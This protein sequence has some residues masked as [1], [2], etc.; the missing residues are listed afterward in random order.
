MAKSK[1]PDKIDTSIELPIVRDNIIQIGS[2]VMNSLR[3]AILQV[4]KTL[5]TNPNGIPSITVAERLNQSLDELGNIKKEAINAL[6]LISGPITNVEVSDNA[7]IAESKLDLDY[8]TS[9]LYAQSL[10]TK[11]QVDSF[12]DTINDLS[13]KISI[14]L[15]ENA[16]NAHMA[17]NIGVEDI[18]ISASDISEFNL[19]SQNVQ[20]VLEQFINNHVNFSGNNISETNNSHK[21]NQI[22]YDSLKS[23]ISASSVQEALDNLSGQDS[24]VGQTLRDLYFENGYQKSSIL[25]VQSNLGRVIYKNMPI[26]F[27]KYSEN[28]DD[29]FSEISYTEELIEAPEKYDFVLISDSLYQI[30]SIDT[31]NKSIV[32]FGNLIEASTSGQTANFLKNSHGV[33]SPAG[34]KLVPVFDTSLS[35][36][37]V[38]KV[39][40]PSTTYI[41]SDNLSIERIDGANQTFSIEVDNILI[42]TFSV[43]SATGNSIDS[44][45]GKINQECS[46]ENLPISAFRHETK[47]GTKIGLAIDY[48]NSDTK[49][50]YIKLTSSD[51]SLDF[52]GLS[53]YKDLKVYGNFGSKYQINGSEFLGFEDKILATD[54]EIISGGNTIDLSASTS[55]VLTSGVKENDLLQ[56]E[57]SSSNDGI[58]RI[59]SVSNTSLKVDIKTGSAFSNETSES[60][61][62]KIQKNSVGLEDIKYE[63]ISSGGFESSFVDLFIDQKQDVNFVQTFEMENSIVG[64]EPLYSIVEAPRVMSDKTYT[65]SLALINTSN[66]DEGFSITF[67]GNEKLVEL[68]KGNRVVEVISSDNEKFKFFIKIEGLLSRLDTAGAINTSMFSHQTL[69]YQNNLFLGRV[70]FDDF[71]GLLAG[72]DENFR[73]FLSSDLGFISENQITNYFLKEFIYNRFSETRSSGVVSGLNISN[74][75][76]STNTTYQFDVSSGTVYVSGERFEVPAQTIVTNINPASSD[77]IFISV[78]ES[79]NLVFEEPINVG[80]ACL[81][82]FDPENNA[83]IGTIEYNSSSSTF[84]LFDLKLRIND[85]DFK[86]FNDILVSPQEG[87]GHFKNLS[88]AIKIAKRFGEAFPSAGVPK[89]KLKAGTYK[90]TISIADVSTSPYGTASTLEMATNGIYID[91]PVI[92]EGEGEDTILDLSQ[93]FT[94]TT[95][96]SKSTNTSNRGVLRIMGNSATTSL[97][98][99][100]KA[101]ALSGNVVIKNLK[102]YNSKIVITDQLYKEGTNF[103]S[104]SVT[105]EGIYFKSDTMW[106]TSFVS[107]NNSNIAANDKSGNIRII[108]CKFEDCGI[109][110]DEVTDAERIQNYEIKG[111]TFSRPNVAAPTYDSAVFISDES[112]TAN[113][114]DL[115]TEK[116]FLSMQDNN[117]HDLTSMV[118]SPIS[119]LTKKGSFPKKGS[120]PGEYFFNKVV[121]STV[122]VD[123]LVLSGSPFTPMSSVDFASLSN[124]NNFNGINEFENTV[125]FNDT[126]TFTSNAIFEDIVAFQGDVTSANVEVENLTVT[127]E[128]DLGTNGASIG[129]AGQTFYVTGDVE[130]QGEVNIS[131]DVTGKRYES[132]RVEFAGLSTDTY[133]LGLMQ[134]SDVALSDPA[135]ATVITRVGSSSFKIAA[136]PLEIEKIILKNIT[137][138]TI[139]GDFSIYRAASGSDPKVSANYTIVRTIPIFSLGPY[140]QQDLANAATSGSGV[141]A[142]DGIIFVL[143]N[144]N[145]IATDLQITVEIIYSYEVT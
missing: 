99:F 119:S 100:P 47:T 115:L 2:E 83:I 118:Q 68:P 123:S 28:S 82:P 124:N 108:N 97:P 135:L 111:C 14:H 70:R 6:N 104:S 91:F 94:D 131:G 121:S 29:T 54:F 25:G 33:S 134:N 63:N 87:M 24:D 71:R 4:E 21:A 23:G 88:S 64:T 117:I 15:N 74:I 42:H 137:S 112:A 17:K 13:L 144:N 60:I 9:T 106:D 67:D 92:I 98:S 140:E 22:Y 102:L 51:N 89:I 81:S 7:S 65:L 61:I 84:A 128:L 78:D 37:K 11:K 43:N 138:D 44:I 59:T 57:G 114:D 8:N 53:K 31:T 85:I 145:V 10:H 79:G 30:F 136:Y 18:T 49:T 113:L 34:L 27:S 90:E 40:N 26:L 1:Y 3:S 139:I 36:S 72:Y 132:L 39:L 55:N 105:L 96:I 62:F 19:K 16:V 143:K 110:V 93:S 38:L 45:V 127:N 125:N 50:Y 80:S 130:F 56:I 20:Q 101:T 133:F 69:N 116:Y 120:E 12:I 41:L 77:K 95:G 75:I 86:I 103:Q 107:S 122:E 129:P 76:L 109:S 126:A 66:K 142:S 52:L 32:I 58:Y 141:T 35:F 48:V 5:G 46:L 73:Q